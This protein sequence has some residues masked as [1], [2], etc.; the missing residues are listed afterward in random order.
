MLA[1]LEDDTGPWARALRTGRKARESGADLALD[2]EILDVRA[3][4]TLRRLTL[5][6]AGQ[7]TES[8][9]DALDPIL[10]HADDAQL[11]GTDGCDLDRLLRYLR[12]VGNPHPELMQV[13]EHL[14]GSP[15]PSASFIALLACHLTRSLPVPDRPDISVPVL[16]DNTSRDGLTGLHPGVA[17]KLSLTYLEQGPPGLHPDPRR[18][19]FFY[20]PTRHFVASLENAWQAS[21][22]A[23]TSASVCWAVDSRGPGRGARQHHRGRQPRRRLRAGAARAGH[24]TAAPRRSHPPPWAQ[25]LLSGLPPADQ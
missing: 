6:L 22:L 23:N 14:N 1:L 18:M 20:S 5:Y 21:P 19:S 25:P 4:Y 7:T 10:A 13:L 15:R 2:P 12:G 3:A 24:P 9:A 8:T 17:G 16:F 11:H